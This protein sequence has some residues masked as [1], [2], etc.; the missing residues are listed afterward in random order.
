MAEK[1]LYDYNLNDVS[2]L[3]FEN[4]G[5]VVIVDPAIDT[6]KTIVCRGMFESLLKESGIYHDLILDLWFHFNESNE[7]VTGEYQI[8]ADNTGVFKTKYSR[9]LKIV[10][11]GEE[12]PRFVQL[13]VYPFE[14]TKKY[15]F[16]MDE[17]ADNE[18]L[19]ETLTSKKIDAVQSTFLFSM[20]IDLV[21]DTTSS[22]NVS[23]ISDDVVNYNLKYSDWRMMIVNMIWPEDQEQF[24]RRTDPEYLKANFTPGRTSSY[25]CMM[26]NLEGKFIWVK[27]IFSRAQTYND[28][29]YRFVFMVQ[30]IHDDSIEMLSTLQTYEEKATKDPLTGLYNHGEIENQFNSAITHRQKSD[31]PISL[32]MMDLDHFKDVNDNYGHAVGDT[33]L[34]HFA[35]IILDIIPEEKF[36][37]GRWGGEEFVLICRDKN[38]TEAAELAESIRAKVDEYLF[39]EIAHITCSIGVTELKADDDFTEAFNRLDKAMYSSKQN[40]RNKVTVL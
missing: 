9:R 14:D 25:D 23:E 27:L 24:L 20:Y 37:A 22:I 6:Y 13:T 1:S 16:V 15:I 10:L 29:D 18:S 8:F 34:Q 5:A 26:R 21:A 40:G 19:Q 36:I 3:F 28:D 17:F 12:K 7:K 31:E 4:V 33:T 35:K 2:G 30:D 32:L 38:S 11:E 39:P